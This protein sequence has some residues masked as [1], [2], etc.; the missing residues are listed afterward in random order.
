MRNHLGEDMNRDVPSDRNLTYTH[1]IYGLQAASLVV[2]LTLIV[3]AVMNYV[4]RTDVQ[5]TWL[6]SHFRWQIRT[7]WFFLLWVVVGSITTVIFVGY[8]ILLA[9]LVW[10]I[11]RIAKGWT[12]LAD[13]R[14]V[15]G[16]V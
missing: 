16:T 4:R 7:F 9:N 3:A 12:R 13:R 14:P 11:Y 10:F 8:L 1:V 6:E 5:G 2:G 15:E